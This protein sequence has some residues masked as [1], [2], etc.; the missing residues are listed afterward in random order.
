MKNRIFIIL[1]T[2]FFSAGLQAN[3]FTSTTK[4]IIILDLINSITFRPVYKILELRK[5]KLPL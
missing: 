4:K 2:V 1:F 5:S 3:I